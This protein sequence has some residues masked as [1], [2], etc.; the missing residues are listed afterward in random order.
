M[1]S[2]AFMRGVSGD[3]NSVVI[4][5]TDSVVP[6][7]TTPVATATG[8]TFTIS[9]YSSSY[10]YALT[11]SRGTVSRSTDDV[12]VTGLAAGESATVTIAVTRT[13]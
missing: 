2:A 7:V 10:T 12:T 11:T 9:N 3:S 5:L 6:T 13:N 4:D 8:F 1:A